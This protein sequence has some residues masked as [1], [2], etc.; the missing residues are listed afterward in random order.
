MFGKLLFLFDFYTHK[1]L[2]DPLI[3]GNIILLINS[4]LHRKT[5]FQSH[6]RTKRPN[7]FSTF[8]GF[9]PTLYFSSQKLKSSMK[10]YVALNISTEPQILYF[11]IFSFVEFSTKHTSLDPVLIFNGFEFQILIELS[12]LE[13]LLQTC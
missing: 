11:N 7:Y 3:D 1:E 9:E 13:I 10:K 6:L 5:L 12:H 2:G 8:K 4:N